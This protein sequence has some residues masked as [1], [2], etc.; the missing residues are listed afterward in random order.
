LF[1]CVSGIA[2]GTPAF[3]YDEV[4]GMT[5]TTDQMVAGHRIDDAVDGLLSEV[6]WSSSTSG[7]RSPVVGEA[8]DD[9]RLT[10]GLL[11]SV[12]EIRNRD[13]ESRGDGPKFCWHWSNCAA[14]I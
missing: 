9:S 2:N 3:L 7:V 14:F 12:K 13:P 10:W 11:Y 1:Q 6:G 8:D 4:P 5:G